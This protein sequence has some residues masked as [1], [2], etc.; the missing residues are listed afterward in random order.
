MIAEILYVVSLLILAGAALALLFSAN[1]LTRE[2]IREIPIDAIREGP[3]G[4]SEDIFARTPSGV[5]RANSALK[6]ITDLVISSLLFLLVLP[7]FMVISILIFAVDG[8]PVLYSQARTGRNGKKFLCLKFRTMVLDADKQLEILLAHDQEARLEW[9][10]SYK[11]RSDPRVIPLI[12]H[13]LRRTSLDEMPQ[14]INI[15][16]GDMSLFG[17]RP[18]EDFR[19]DSSGGYRDIYLSVRP[20]LIGPWQV[21]RR[22]VESVD[23]RVRMEVDYITNWSV[24]RDLG[25][26]LG[27]WRLVVAPRSNIY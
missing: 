12:G 8:V 23:E 11:L 5:V 19:L 27:L 21:S 1:L 14:L 9:E 2:R 24:S 18:L 4:A 15:M 20:G 26:L 6:R 3:S 7:I 22:K 16:R 17:P 13:F 10:S 25:L